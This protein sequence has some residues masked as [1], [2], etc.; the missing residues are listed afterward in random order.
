MLVTG[1]KLAMTISMGPICPSLWLDRR[2]PRSGDLFAAAFAEVLVN[3]LLIRYFCGM[4][5][6]NAVKYQATYSSLCFVFLL[7][8]AGFL[9]AYQAST[10]FGHRS[11]TCLLLLKELQDTLIM[12][13]AVGVVF[14]SDLPCGCHSSSHR[15]YQTFYGNSKL[16][17]DLSCVRDAVPPLI[18]GYLVLLV[19][20]T[21]TEVTEYTGSA[22]GM[23][24]ISTPEEGGKA[25]VRGGA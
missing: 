22:L 17:S 5:D 6:R 12:H 24:V 1:L 10:C 14:D 7:F 15:R 8:P 4:V 3:S 11:M 19:F 20:R 16:I 18:W 13:D 23:P 21:R 9:D 2:G 25:I